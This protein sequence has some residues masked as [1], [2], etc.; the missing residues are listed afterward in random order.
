MMPCGATTRRPAARLLLALMTAVGAVHACAAAST[1]PLCFT[2]FP[3]YVS[4]DAPDGGSLGALALR[5]FASAGIAVQIIRAPWARAY[6]MALH[7]D[8]LLMAVWRNDERDRLLS[9]SLPVAR[10]QLGWFVRSE[11]RTAP[12]AT[13]AD[14]AVERGSYQP[15]LLM[16]GGY[17]IH[18]VVDRQAQLQML[19]RARVE[20]VFT[21]RTSFEH[22]LA[23]EAVT[24]VRWLGPAV[25][26][27]TAYMALSK[28]HPEAEA[29]LDL[30]NREIRRTVQRGSSRS[31]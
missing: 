2:D 9:Y 5:A 3:P 22:L 15:P 7:G 21:E 23:R 4:M 12:L 16:N 30:L 28:T 10:M 1:V 25:E 6:T 19:R 14:I 18:P 13:D 20:A 24:D 17:R 31:P 27:K 29:W 8:C 11:R 26:V